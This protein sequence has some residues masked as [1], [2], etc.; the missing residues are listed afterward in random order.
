M[1]TLK[2]PFAC[3]GLRRALRGISCRGGT[4]VP[5]VVREMSHTKYA[6]RRCE[7]GAVQRALAAA[8]AP[9]PAPQPDAPPL[10]GASG[11]VT[12][13]LEAADGQHV[14]PGPRGRAAPLCSSRSRTARAER[15]RTGTGRRW[16][17]KERARKG[18]TGRGWGGGGGTWA[19][20][21]TRGGSTRPGGGRGTRGSTSREHSCSGPDGSGDAGAKRCRRRG[22]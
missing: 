14:V 11:G 21:A 6:P 16:R 10:M 2:S 4:R 13:K 9:A 17:R 19:A 18:A 8:P 15:T 5:P 7:G 3:V 1:R 12:V 20:A 22:C